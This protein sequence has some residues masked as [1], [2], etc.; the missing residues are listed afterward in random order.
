MLTHPPEHGNQTDL[1]Q[2]QRSLE[3]GHMLFN[4]PLQRREI[5]RLSH[6]ARHNAKVQR[7]IKRSFEIYTYVGVEMEL[8]PRRTGVPRSQRT[9]GHL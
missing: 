4:V 8:N 9:L 3:S 2:T 6:F 1:L 7:K 5:Y